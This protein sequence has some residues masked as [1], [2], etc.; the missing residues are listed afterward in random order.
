MRGQAG[1]V[2]R[3][4]S[5]CLRESMSSRQTLEVRRQLT[6]GQFCSASQIAPANSERAANAEVWELWW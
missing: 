6:S 5:D 1:G 2:K 3:N 4:M